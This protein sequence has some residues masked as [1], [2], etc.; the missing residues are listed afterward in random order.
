MTPARSM[1]IARVA[2]YLPSRRDP[3][4]WWHREPPVV[5]YLYLG[6]TPPWFSWGAPETAPE[7]KLREDVLGE[8]ARLLGMGLD[9]MIDDRHIAAGGVLFH[10]LGDEP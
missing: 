9:V 8:R 3:L 7:T 6:K 2:G 10:G 1:A 4:L 5:Y